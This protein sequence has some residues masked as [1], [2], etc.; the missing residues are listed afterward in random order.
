VIIHH[1]S[2]GAAPMLR[3]RDVLSDK[4]I[5]TIQVGKPFTFATGIGNTKTYEL[6]KTGELESIKVGKRRLIVMESY[7]RYIAKQL[8]EGVPDDHCADAAHEATRKKHRER[9]EKRAEQP[10]VADVL[11][12]VGLL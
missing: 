7:R 4:E 11:R 1:D 12:Q 6:L 9:R 5:I 3:A 8:A 10:K 2:D